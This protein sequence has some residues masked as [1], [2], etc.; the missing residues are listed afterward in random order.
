[1][2]GQPLDANV[3]V[4]LGRTANHVEQERPRCGRES[5][6][7]LGHPLF[8]HFG[9]D[10][11][12]G[13][14]DMSEFVGNEF[15]RHGRGVG[16]ALGQVGRILDGVGH[17]NADSTGH[18]HLDVEGFGN[19]ENVREE[20]GGIDGITAQGLEGAL[21][22]VLGM[23]QKFQEVPSGLLLVVPVFRQMTSG[24]S[25]EPHGS[26]FHVLPAQRGADHEVVLGQGRGDVL[27]GGS[28]GG[29]CGGSCCIVIGGRGSCVGRHEVQDD[30]PSELE[31]F[32]GRRGRRRHGQ[33]LGRRSG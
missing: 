3:V 5:N 17:L 24:L 10:E 31:I 28:G 20:D 18:G 26:A 16:D 15:L 25:E 22:D 8:R 1:M 4:L 29:G 6:E 32:L 23:G 13:R 19:N 33:C 7:G 12:D 2:V 21:G 9:F 14:N 30:L 11:L 27:L